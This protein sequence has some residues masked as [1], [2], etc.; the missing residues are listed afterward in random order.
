M[1]R[2]LTNPKREDLPNS[3]FC[4]TSAG[5]HLNPAARQHGIENPMGMHAGDM[6]NIQVGSD[7]ALA[8]EVLNPAVTLRPGVNSL[9]KEGGTALV[10]HG[11]A[12]DHTS[13]PAGNAGP[14]IACGVVTH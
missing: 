7:G 13:D 14:R 9:F 2:F 6:P 10:L 3:R 4:F 11:G 8:F 1:S 5:G 12:D